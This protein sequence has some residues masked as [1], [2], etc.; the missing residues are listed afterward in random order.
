M[1]ADTIKVIAFPGGFNLPLWAAIER[2]F[3]QSRGLNVELHYT[4]NSVEQLSGTDYRA[5]GDRSHWF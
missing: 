1:S 4:A 2:K 5:L 3:F